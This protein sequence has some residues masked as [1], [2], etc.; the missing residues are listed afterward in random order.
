MQ[1]ESIAF[2]AKLEQDQLRFKDQKQQPTVPTTN[3][4]AKSTL[5]S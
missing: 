5:L 2:Q 1:R 4:A 3:D